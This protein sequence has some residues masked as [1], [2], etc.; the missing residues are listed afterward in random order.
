MNKDFL[1]RKEMQ[2]LPLPMEREMQGIRYR[3]GFLK[4]GTGKKGQLILQILAQTIIKAYN[5]V[6]YATFLDTRFFIFG[7]SFV[8]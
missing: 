4:A 3:Y 5:R 6:R 7:C 8:L 1:G 2:A